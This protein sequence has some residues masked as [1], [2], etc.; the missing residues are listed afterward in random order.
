VDAEISRS[1]LLTS[2]ITMD[3]DKRA[4]PRGASITQGWM[5]VKPSSG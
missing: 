5:I 3:T 4:V 1:S 2:T